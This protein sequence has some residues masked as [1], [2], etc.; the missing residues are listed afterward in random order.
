MTELIAPIVSLQRVSFRV[1]GKTLLE[2][3]SLDV[4]VGERVVILGANGAGKSTLLKLCASILEPSAGEISSA[5]LREQAFIFQRPAILRRSV[6]DN[7]RY[8]LRNRSMNEPECSA[9]ARL[10]LEVTELTSFALQPA[11]T[12]SGGEQQRLALARAWACQPRLLLADEPTASLSPAAAREVERIIEAVHA[13][14]A[15]LIFTTHNLAQAKRL[16]QR[17]VFLDGGRIVEDRPA[18]EFFSAPQS[19]AARHYLEGETL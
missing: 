9:R 6:L 8:V 16:A 3:V 11:K 1:N 7:V 4:Q 12:L 18:S 13:T 5:P 2:D 14:G 17:I 15:T 10:A 19:G